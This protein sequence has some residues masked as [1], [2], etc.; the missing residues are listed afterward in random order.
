MISGGLLAVIQGAIT[1]RLGEKALALASLQ[2]SFFCV[3]A[4]GT[5]D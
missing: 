3:S 2:H 1:E 5:F 4:E